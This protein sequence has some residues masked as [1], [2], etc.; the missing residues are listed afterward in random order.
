MRCVLH[1][2]VASWSPLCDCV[3]LMRAVFSDRDEA[4]RRGQQ[5]REDMRR[6]YSPR[7][8]AAQIEARIAALSK[9][10]ARMRKDDL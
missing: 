8:I 7:V 6:K 4:R 5:A 2:A 10:S 1:L 3:Q 9:R